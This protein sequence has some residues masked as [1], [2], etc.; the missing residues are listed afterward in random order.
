[1]SSFP[2]VLSDALDTELNWSQTLNTIF[3]ELKSR[4]VGTIAFDVVVKWQ[5]ALIVI[6]HSRTGDARIKAVEQ[7]KQYVRPDIRLWDCL[8]GDTS[9]SFSFARSVYIDPLY[10]FIGRR[11]LPRDERGVLHY[12]HARRK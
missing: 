6:I 9:C 11:G 1:M 12:L 7:L 4:F 10:F 2:I 5:L 3:A 8:L